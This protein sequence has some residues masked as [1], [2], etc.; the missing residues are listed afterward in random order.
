MTY[1]EI[2][3]EA[4]LPDLINYIKL[5]ELC[6]SV[7]GAEIVMKTIFEPYKACQLRIAQ[8][9]RMPEEQGIWVD[10]EVF[11]PDDINYAEQGG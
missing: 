8:I 11:F 2:R 3:R 7:Y 10:V 5:S 9:S 1:E 6:K 4:G